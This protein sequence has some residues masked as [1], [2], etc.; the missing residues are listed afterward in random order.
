MG[1]LLVDKPKGITSHDV[2]DRLRKVTGIK[3]IGHAGTLDPN[4]TGLLLIAITR[5]YTKKLG[6]LSSYTKKRYIADITLGEERSTHDVEGEIIN[7]NK[8][9]I[10]DKKDI[11]EALESF[12]GEIDQVPPKHSALKINGK[13]AYDLARKNAEF[14][15]QS[16][17]ITVYDVKIV[18]YK[19]PILKLDI[20][21]SSGTYIRSIAR[22][23]G[24]KLKTFGYLSDLRRTQIGK[25]KLEDAHKLD[26]INSDNWKELE[27]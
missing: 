5:E 15:M 23:L 14:E 4:A 9:Y 25:Y 8:K 11:V 6:E 2:I 3:K 24:R 10:P 7:S 20:D 13:K 17:K 12:K 16:R 26:S 18:S 21:C 1:I 19:Y 27:I 22:D